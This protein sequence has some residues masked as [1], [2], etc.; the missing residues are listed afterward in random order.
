MD[1]FIQKLP[2]KVFVKESSASASVDEKCDIIISANI[3]SAEKRLGDEIINDVP[4][5]SAEQT[6]GRQFQNSWLKLYGWLESMTDNN[7]SNATRA[8]C[9]ICKECEKLN[10][11]KFSTKRDMCFIDEEDSPELQQ[12][13]EQ[14]SYQWTSKDIQNELLEIMSHSVLRSV[15]SDIHLRKYYAILLD[16]TCDIA[17][18]EQDI[19]VMC[20]EAGR[21]NEMWFRCRN[22]AKWAHELCTSVSSA[23]DYIC[24]FCIHE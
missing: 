19:C 14:T 3:T 18:K 9:K 10:L 17:I 22:C 13:L 6:V 12:W 15:I 20:G 21:D 8:F 4:K 7:N 2:K 23:V 5:K 1:K 11:F 16:E 24:E